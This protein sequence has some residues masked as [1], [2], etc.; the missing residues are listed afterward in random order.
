MRIGIDA[1]ELIGHATGVGRYLGALLRE[2]SNGP[3]AR[4]HQFVLYAPEPLALALDARRFCTREVAGAPGTWWEQMRL[5]QAIAGDPL[6]V[7]FAP[8]YT[9]PLRTKVPIVV[10]IHDLS[11]MAHPEWFRLGEGARRRWLTQMTAEKARAVVTVS[12]FSRGEIINH[13]KIPEQRVH[14][15]ASGID[16]PAIRPAAYGEARVLY[17]GSIFNRRHVPELIRAVSVLRR[18]RP[19]ISLDIVGDDR[20]FPRE[21]L[22]AAIS[23][24]Q[25]EGHVRWHRY[26][27]DEQLLELYGRARVFAFLSEYEGLGMTPL[28]A[29]AAGVPPVVYDTAVARESYGP[30]ALYVPVGDGAGV[31]R[32]L[33]R[34]LFDEQ[35]RATILAAAPTTLA[36]Y[37]WPRAAR[38]TLAVIES[39]ASVVKPFS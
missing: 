13:L 29:L 39:A 2:W 9:A 6:D 31:V 12:Q 33:E 24:Q 23:H 11:Y 4:A 14:A 38:E 5:P 20:T 35:A 28:E 30:A 19:D 7:F 34:A 16:R 8:A 37:E 15:I 32:A 25:L 22:E 3:A 27:T 1:R 36:K 18:T 21:N 10:T 17:V 26:A